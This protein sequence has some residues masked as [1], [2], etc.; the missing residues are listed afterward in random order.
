MA[1]LPPLERSALRSALKCLRQSKTHSGS[2]CV[3]FVFHRPGTNN[4]PCQSWTFIAAAICG[5]LGILVTYL[6]IPDMTGVDLM[7]EDAR[8]LRYLGENGW[9]GE[10]GEGGDSERI[11]WLEIYMNEEV[12]QEGEDEGREV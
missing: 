3:F 4:S 9:E 2:G 12:V 8:F 1:F 11:V 6:F 7:E 5:A 10:V